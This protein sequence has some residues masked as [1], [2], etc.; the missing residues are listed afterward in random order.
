MEAPAH[1]VRWVLCG[2]GIC[3]LGLLVYGSLV[4]PASQPSYGPTTPP[5]D[6]QTGLLCATA[7]ASALALSLGVYH[8]RFWPVLIGAGVVGL[9]LGTYYAWVYFVPN[10]GDGARY[11]YVAPYTLLGSVLS[12]WGVL[13]ILGGGAVLWLANRSRLRSPAST[14]PPL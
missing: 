10:M 1:W 14:A 11:G 2:L 3:L 9:A 6:D 8:S 7:L 4:G 5:Q 12:M 13:V